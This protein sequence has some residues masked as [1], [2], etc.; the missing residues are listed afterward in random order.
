[1]TETKPSRKMFLEVVQELRTL[2]R[3]ENILAG[4]KLPSERVLAERLGTGRSTIRE[5]LRSLE[6]LGLIESRQGEGT[7]LSDFRKHQ[8]VEVL[9]AFIMQEPK[10]LEDV[11]ATM[12]IHEKEAVRS[13]SADEETRNLPLW[14][15]LIA[16]AESEA[17]YLREDIVREVLIASG[18]RL[19]LK[20]WHLLY[21]YAGKPYT[22][23]AGSDER[24]EI[25]CMLRKI[26]SGETEEA[27]AAYDRWTAIVHAQRGNTDGNHPRDVQKK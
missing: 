25:A 13:A 27:V 18:N 24:T 19:S 6:L 14:T 11:R 16:A 2:I 21:Q 8:L 1:M 4:D 22:G 9:A 10:S 12:Q 3:N 15:G 26:R 5:A 7:F 17:P 20:I 23:E